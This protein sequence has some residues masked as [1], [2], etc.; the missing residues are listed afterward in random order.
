MR[1]LADITADYSWPEMERHRA[2][3]AAGRGRRSTRWRWTGM[4]CRG[5]M[6]ASSEFHRVHDGVEVQRIAE[7]EEIVAQPRDVRLG[8]NADGDLCGEHLGA[9]LHRAEAARRQ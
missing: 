7:L 9:R 3:S 6:A 8:G 4:R 1:L 5:G 2:A